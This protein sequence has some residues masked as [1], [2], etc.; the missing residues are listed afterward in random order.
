MRKN[1]VTNTFAPEQLD[2]TSSA[3]LPRYKFR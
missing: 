2:K 3:A 1:K